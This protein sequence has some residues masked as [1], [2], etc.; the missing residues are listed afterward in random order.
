MRCWGITCVLSLQ[1]QARCTT[2]SPLAHASPATAVPTSST[3][4]GGSP[5]HLQTPSR[6]LQCTGNQRNACSTA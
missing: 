1:Q 5:T 4:C 2:C 3:T 6:Q